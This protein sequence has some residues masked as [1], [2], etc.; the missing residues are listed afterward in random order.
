MC[1]SLKQN[2]RLRWYPKKICSARKNY[3][4]RH[5]NQR[6]EKTGRRGLGRYVWNKTSNLG[7]KSDIWFQ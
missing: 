3:L 5:G 1:G 4:L 2:W 7:R 6:K